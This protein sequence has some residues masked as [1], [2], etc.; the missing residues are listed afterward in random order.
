MKERSIG[1]MIVL[2]IIT[3]GL[4]ALI[5][6]IL[7]QIELREKTNQGFGGFM[8]FIMLFITFG[9]YG[10]YWQYA[11]GKR[12]AMQGADDNS[13]LYLIL[14]LFGLGWLN[15]FIMQSQANKLLLTT[16]A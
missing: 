16:S 11:A 10:V 4:Y 8:H 15:M 12:L 9:I 7:F 3:F 5:W 14:A 1:A 6:M 2:T 13:V